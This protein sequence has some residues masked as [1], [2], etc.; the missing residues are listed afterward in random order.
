[1]GDDFP[2]GQY[3]PLPT[4]YHRSAGVQGGHANHALPLEMANFIAGDSNSQD[5]HLPSP[6]DEFGDSEN[7]EAHAEVEIE[8]DRDV[9]DPT[10]IQYIFRE[11]TW[12]QSHYTYSPAPREFVEHSGAHDNFRRMPSFLQL[13][14]LLCLY[15]VLRKI[16]VETNRYAG[17]PNADG[18]CP[19]GPSWYQFTVAELKAYLAVQMFMGLKTQS[20][21]K[22]YWAR[23]GSFFHCL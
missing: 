2:A 7:E 22:I 11:T 1:M 23:R 3:D 4:E 10:S 8:Q 20:N 15:T 18:I 21:L 5:S 14:S 12:S 16:V 17:T 19:G 6:I 13:F 9:D